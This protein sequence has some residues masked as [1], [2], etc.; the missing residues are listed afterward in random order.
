MAKKGVGDNFGIGSNKSYTIIE[1]AE[2]LEMSY[3]MTNRKKGNRLDA[4][5]KT[6]KTKELGWKPTMCL[7]EYLQNHFQ[8]N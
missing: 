3:K 5:L 7:K 8:K 2:M 4:S 1:V 6:T